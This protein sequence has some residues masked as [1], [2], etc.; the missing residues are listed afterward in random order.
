M[1][2]SS[3]VNKP[4]YTDNG[5]KY[6]RFSGGKKVGAIVATGAGIVG[7]VIGKDMHKEMLETLKN[8]RFGRASYIAGAILGL[9]LVAAV[10][11]GIGAIVDAV[12]NKV[13]RSKADQAATIDTQ[14]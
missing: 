7:N 6:N 1:N 9:G 11:T 3:I 8:V 4:A 10:G 13:R 14:A 5:N 2:V 12:V